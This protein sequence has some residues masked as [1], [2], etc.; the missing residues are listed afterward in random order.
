[1]AG[2]VSGEL[3]SYLADL[4][5]DPQVLDRLLGRKAEL[6]A[7]ERRYGVPIDELLSD[8]SRLQSDALYL[9]SSDEQI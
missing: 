9:D 7:I 5:A 8:L 2:D 4:D 6:V 1:M 3:S